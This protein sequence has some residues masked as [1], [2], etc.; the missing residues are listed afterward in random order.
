M[1]MNRIRKT[2][3]LLLLCII[4]FF[5]FS[6]Q[7]IE[8]D[9][10]NNTIFTTWLDDPTSTMTV[11][12]LANGDPL[13]EYVN[14][15]VDLK[16]EGGQVVQN[17]SIT[18]SKFYPGGTTEIYVCRLH[19]TNLNPDQYYYFNYPVDG[20]QYSFRTAPNN[21]DKPIVFAQGGDVGLNNADVVTAHQ[22]AGSWDPLFAFLGGDLAY[23]NGLEDY[24]FR[25]VNYL[26]RWSQNMRGPDGNLVPM[27]VT[28]GNHEVANGGHGQ[29]PD[30]ARLF[31]SLFGGEPAK[32]VDGTFANFDF[33]NYLRIIA[34][35]SDHTKG[36]PEQNNWL[37]Q[38]LIEGEAFNFVFPIYHVPAYPGNRP[39]TASNSTAIRENWSPLFEE[40]K[41]QIA[42]EHHDHLYK[43]THPIVNEEVVEGGVVYVGDGCWGKTP[44]DVGSGDRPYLAVAKAT[45]NI[46]KV[47]LDATKALF[48]VYNNNKDKID[49]FEAESKNQYIEV[50][51]ADFSGS[52][53]TILEGEAVLFNDS[54]TYAK[55]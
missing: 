10:L 14:S 49:S 36:I 53:T 33:G 21:L 54:S 12:W 38:S 11:Q 30:Q 55:T 3:Y 51:T 13:P 16:D 46:I 8:K 23:C 41:V 27:L 32:F 5:S 37:E 20:L 1:K 9:D 39:Y 48:E 50:P 17:I 28:I 42:F 4:P 34:L 24:I 19:F 7:S 25:W 45:D 22:M 44:R 2:I 18:T 31:Y 47:T 35:D 29:T 43:R 52:N 15:K 6:Q 40:Y 26:T